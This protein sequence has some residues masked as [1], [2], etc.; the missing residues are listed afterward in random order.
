[1]VRLGWTFVMVAGGL[2]ALIASALA[3]TGLSTV[4]AVLA[5]LNAVTFLG[6]GYDKHQARSGGL[7]VPEAT[8][9]VLSAAGGTPGAF[10]GQRLFHH[11]TR[12]RRFQVIFWVIVAVQIVVLLAI[13]HLR[14]S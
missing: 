7:R 12:D 6:Y 14:R 3:L 2:A 10:I 13:V 11:K 9:H 5:A 8:L 4:P 1:M